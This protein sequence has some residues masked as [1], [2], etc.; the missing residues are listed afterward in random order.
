MGGGEGTGLAG[1][2]QRLLG[3]E[4]VVGQDE[5]AGSRDSEDARV[6]CQG[7]GLASDAVSCDGTGQVC[8]VEITPVQKSCAHGIRKGKVQAPRQGNWRERGGRL[9][10]TQGSKMDGTEEPGRTD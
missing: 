8:G 7:A 2:R 3:T 4:Q 1:E 9:T 10:Q 5:L 6:L